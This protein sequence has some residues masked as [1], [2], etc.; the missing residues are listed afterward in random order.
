[1]LLVCYSASFLQP[2]TC[3]GPLA[4]EWVQ[5]S[6]TWWAVLFGHFIC[7]V[8]WWTRSEAAD[9]GYIGNTTS[10]CPCLQVWQVSVI[11]CCLWPLMVVTSLKN[12]SCT[13]SHSIASSQW[14]RRDGDAIHHLHHKHKTQ[15]SNTTTTL[16]F[17]YHTV[18]VVGSNEPFNLCHHGEW[19]TTFS[20]V[21]ANRERE[22][23]TVYD[24]SVMTYSEYWSTPASGQWPICTCT[25]V[26]CRGA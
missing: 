22:I 10:L 26:P 9:G 6:V 19:G 3:T 23:F 18:I 24:G 17:S 12:C 5:T 7:Q 20:R 1:M 16:I 2:S 4:Y 21:R 25:P 13:S 15:E 11:D 8:L 14:P